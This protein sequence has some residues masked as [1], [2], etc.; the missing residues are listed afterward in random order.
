MC[1]LPIQLRCVCG[2]HTDT[3]CPCDCS[4]RTSECTYGDDWCDGG[5]SS[6]TTRMCMAPAGG[7]GR[8][9]RQ[10]RK[11]E[12]ERERERGRGCRKFFLGGQ[13]VANLWIS[14]R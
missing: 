8:C 5:P 3:V 4:S 1:A 9:A 7:G 6:L 14:A 12:K 13:V 10:G 11:R 2:R